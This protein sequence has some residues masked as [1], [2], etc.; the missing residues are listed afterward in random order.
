[1]R[2]ILLFIRLYWKIFLVIIIG[3]LFISVSFILIMGKRF[4]YLFNYGVSRYIAALLLG[5]IGAS[6]IIYFVFALVRKIMLSQEKGSKIWRMQF[7]NERLETGLKIVSLGGGTGLPVILNGINRYTSNISAVVTMFDDGGSSGKLREQLNILPPGDIR[8]CLFALAK[9][10]KLM[11]ELFQYRFKS[12]D[13]KGHPVGNVLLAAMSKI[14]GD[15]MKKGIAEIEKILSIRGRVLPVTF[16][17]AILSAIKSKS[18][19]LVEGESSINKV[20]GK[21]YDIF[22]NPRKLKV[23][24]DVIT[25]IKNAEIITLG[26]GSLF[27]SVIPNLLVKDVCNA[28]NQ[29]KVPVVYICNLM[30]ESGETDGFNV[31]DH[32]NAILE[33]SSL[34]KIDYVLYNLA[35]ISPIL[36]ENYQHEDAFPVKVDY[37]NFKK[38]K[39]IEFIGDDLVIEENSVRHNSRKIA[40]IIYST[41]EKTS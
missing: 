7:F 40:D 9:S 26:P 17:H 29:T 21:F 13:L 14:S 30:T 33:F 25:A 5:G 12:G 15:D 2:Q 39:N 20:Q 31:T 27:T 22:T 4:E 19:T 34:E 35:P 36:L 32:I 23:N 18:K 28:L 11:K 38:F 24:N 8:N 10:G 3:S 37:V 41:Y 16:E 1:M 6:I